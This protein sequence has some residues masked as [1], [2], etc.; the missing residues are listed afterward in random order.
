[1]LSRAGEIF[2]CFNFQIYKKR[3]EQDNNPSCSCWF[4]NFFALY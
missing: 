2:T 4:T 1:M 3:Q